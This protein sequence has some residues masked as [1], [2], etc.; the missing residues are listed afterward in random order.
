MP[1]LT[2]RDN[3]RLATCDP[4]LDR[5]VRYIS[6]YW[7]CMVL[8][9]HRDQATQDAAFARGTSKL[10]WPH[11]K[12]NAYPSTAVD[13][14]PTPLDWTDTERFLAFADFVT[15]AARRLRIPI[16]WGGDWD[17]DPATLNRF[18]D[19]VHFELRL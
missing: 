15:G 10:R 18:N 9:G 12:H 7:P 17:G 2:T 5:L 6:L 14:A 16:R 11:G 4:R 1:A 8:E 13:L 19:L 3:A